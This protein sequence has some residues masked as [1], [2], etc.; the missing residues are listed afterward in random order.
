MRLKRFWTKVHRVCNKDNTA[1]TIR[2]AGIAYPSR[3]PEITPEFYC[4]MF[5]RSLNLFAIVYF[6]KKKTSLINHISGKKSD[7]GAESQDA[8]SGQ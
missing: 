1:G 3:V 7:Y 2:G 4:V 5:C 6:E 8:I